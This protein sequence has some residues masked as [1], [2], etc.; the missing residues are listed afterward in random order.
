MS[1]EQFS[2]LMYALK[3]IEKQFI[4]DYTKKLMNDAEEALN[5]D[6]FIEKYDPAKPAMNPNDTKRKKP[7]PK[8][9]KEPTS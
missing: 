8:N 7:K 6:N 2:G 4:D 1:Q 3:A 9:T 5:I